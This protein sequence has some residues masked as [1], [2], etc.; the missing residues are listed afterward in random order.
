[1]SE[2]GA[3]TSAVA[4]KLGG[5]FSRRNALL[6]LGGAVGASALTKVSSA[7]A[8]GTALQQGPTTSGQNRIQ[9]TG[10]SAIDVVNLTIKAVSG[11]TADLT[12]WQDQTG[13]VVAQILAD[14]GWRMRGA[15]HILGK[16]AGTAPTSS[17]VINFKN[18]DGAAAEQWKWSV[19][20]LMNAIDNLPNNDF[21]ITR[22][23]PDNS[24]VTPFH[25]REYTTWRSTIGIN[26]SPP[27]LASVA[28]SGPDN[29]TGVPTLLIR[30]GANQTG[31][32]M[33]FIVSSGARSAHIG[34][35]SSLNVPAISIGALNP[36]T[37]GTTMSF[38][39]LRVSSPDVN[40]PNGLHLNGRATNSGPDFKLR[41][42]ESSFYGA[43]FMQVTDRDSTRSFLSIR[44]DSGYVGI[45]NITDMLAPLDVDGNSIRL[46]QP[47][48]PASAT[49]AGNIGTITWDAGYVYVCV[50]PSTWKRV[51]L[52]V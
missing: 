48:T 3:S 18:K 6:A 21:G 36:T 45:G 1:M 2:T 35:D 10:K 20:P 29:S 49:A 50:A 5:V 26:F 15:L 51:A 23:N 52:V 30:A 7:Q 47:E 43:R 46:R 11:Q 9:S 12:Q 14:G 34:V 37:P 32:I 42:L 17:P 19:G 22:S 28:V 25:I 27:P 31:E 16:S 39:A 40:V 4:A 33:R 41:S 44:D 24:T 13:R 8:A 38:P